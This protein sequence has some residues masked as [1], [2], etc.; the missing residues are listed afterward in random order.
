[1]RDFIEILRRLNRI[2]AKID[3]VTAAGERDE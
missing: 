1:M 3:D 2:D